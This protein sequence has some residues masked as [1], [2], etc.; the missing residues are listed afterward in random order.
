MNSRRHS[1]AAAAALTAVGALV[2]SGC[3]GGTSDGGDGDGSSMTLWHNSTTGPGVEFWE[4]TVADFEEANP[5]VSIT[6]QSIQN[7]D[8]DGKLQTALNSGDAP[9]I[10]LQR[11]GGKMAA[12][13]KAGQLKDLT[14]S[15]SDA[16]TDE[17][18]A[19]AFSAAFT[20]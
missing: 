15:L 3:T 16:V 17:I 8:L 20:R 2:L 10:F 11:G 5:G 13:V 6:V 1:L 18:P 9:D 19:A 7:E 12:M 4:K 14:G